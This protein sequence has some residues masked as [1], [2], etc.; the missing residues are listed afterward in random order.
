MLLDGAAKDAAEQFDVLA[1]ADVELV[2]DILLRDREG[3]PLRLGGR[4]QQDRAKRGIG[5]GDVRGGREG[6]RKCAMS[7]QQR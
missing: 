4:G 6:R 3:A 1:E 7:Q 5:D 2:R